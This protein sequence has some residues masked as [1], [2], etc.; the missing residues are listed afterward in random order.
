MS[1]CPNGANHSCRHTCCDEE[2]LCKRWSSICRHGKKQL[3]VLSPKQSQVLRISAHLF[4]NSGN[5]RVNRQRVRIKLHTN[6]AGS[7]DVRQVSRQ[8]I[9][10]INCHGY[11]MFG[12]PPASSNAR[13][14]HTLRCAYRRENSS[15]N[16]RSELLIFRK[17]NSRRGHT[18]ASCHHHDFSWPGLIPAQQPTAHP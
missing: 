8:P 18:Q 6:M 4:S 15:R 2:F 7:A 1:V 16:T 14:W 13:R 10:N 5:V 12:E 3:V 11:A 17:Q 9:A